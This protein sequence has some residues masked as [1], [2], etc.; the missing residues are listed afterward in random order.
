MDLLGASIGLMLALPVILLA[1]IAIKL[2]SKGPVFF[3][4]MRSGQ[5]GSAFPMYKLR[6]MVVDAEQLKENLEVLNERD[7]PAFKLE[8]DPRVTR[9]GGLLRKT[10]LDEL[11]QLWNVLIGQMALV[12]P[13][14]LP[15]D[16]AAKCEWWQ[17]RRLDTKPG[18][19]CTWQISKSS[20]ISFSEWMRLDLNYADNRTIIG[21]FVLILKTAKAVF[22]GRVGH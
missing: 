5:F 12:G 22:L 20:K 1:A 15:C 18:L 9:I 8:N 21:D 7:G 10:G 3:R 14:P 11:P 17:R 13:R 19:T 16:E 6:T 4:Q 2:T